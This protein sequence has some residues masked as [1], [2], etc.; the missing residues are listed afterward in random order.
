M[1]IS[2]AAG[3]NNCLHLKMIGYCIDSVTIDV[4]NSF[5]KLNRIFDL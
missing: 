2:Y 3:D 1:E 5:T 4:Y